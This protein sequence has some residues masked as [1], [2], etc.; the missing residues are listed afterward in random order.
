MICLNKEMEI[1]RLQCNFQKLSF[2]MLK[3]QLLARNLLAFAARKI[4]D[5]DGN[6]FFLCFRL[7]RSLL[8]GESKILVL[9]HFLCHEKERCAKKKDEKT[10]AERVILGKICY[11]CKIQSNN[12]I[13]MLL[14]LISNQQCRNTFAKHIIVHT[15]IHHRSVDS[16]AESHFKA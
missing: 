6:S 7:I 9:K 16:S 13:S 3:A 5:G 2:R 14:M 1:N 11:L 15:K 12:D 10:H 8:L 4:R